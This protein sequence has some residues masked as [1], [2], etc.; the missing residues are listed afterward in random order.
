MID[1]TL[2][3]YTRKKIRPLES[4]R[5]RITKLY[6]E[7]KDFLGEHNCFQTGSYARFTAIRPVHDLDIFYIFRDGKTTLGAQQ[8][9]PEVAQ[10]IEQE[11]SKVCSE[12]FT[13]DT[14]THSV[15]LSF[16]DDFSID[17]VPAVETETVTDDFGDPIYIV[18][19]ESS[20]EW[21]YSDPKG[22][23]KLTKETD[24]TAD[25]KL[26]YAIRLVK[27]W[28]KGCKD[29][30]DDFKLKSFH[31]E[32]MMIEIFEEKPS[33]DL[34][35]AVRSFFSK[36]PEN[37]LT[38]RFEDRAY[39]NESD[40][41]YIDQYISELTALERA[42]IINLSEVQ[43]ELYNSMT[44]EMDEEEIDALLNSYLTC[45]LPVAKTTDNS[46]VFKP[47]GPHKL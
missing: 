23:K 16:D 13:V 22:Y 32:Q 19:V 43:E 2:K 5:T 37:L 33:I 12:S 47:A 42:E 41:V 8:A 29:R 7:L 35:E 44:E 21:I 27:A 45:Q 36:V 20:G 1:D 26:R 38:P 40:T 15:K 24:D 11:F 30:D 39:V 25:N 10:S 34:H 14:Q 18:P 17:V 31:I 28:R 46:T 3:K 6:G 4:Q 9:L